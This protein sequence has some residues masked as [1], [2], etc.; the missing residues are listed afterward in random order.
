MQL[1]E[2][3]GGVGSPRCALRNIGVP[4][5]SIDYVEIDEKAVRS[6][7]AMFA[8]ELAY[9]AQD[10]CGW[11]LRPDILVHGSPCQDFSIAGK[12]QGA[13]PNS[14]TRSSL[15]WETI[16]TIKNMGAW[17]PKIVVWEN[18]KNVRSKYM[19]HNH[20]R[21]IDELAKMGYTS[22]FSL[23]DA[24]DFGLPQARQRYFTVSCLGGKAFNFKK[25]KKRP[26]RNVWDFIQPD[27]EVD[28]R[29][30]IKSPSM[31]SRIDPN[32]YDIARLNKLP[33]IRN[34]VCTI[35]TTQDR[36]PNAGIIRRDNGKWRLLTERECW[37]LQGYSD[38]DFENA[39]KGCP[40]KP[41]FK[42]GALYKQAGN[43]IPVTI[44]E[45]MFEA[46]LDGSGFYKEV[47]LFSDVC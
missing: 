16:N 20:N 2:L 26:M 36:C 17:R 30:T 38:A 25:M 23:L 19:V 15:M 40:G 47:N 12:Q 22:T 11:N 3:F 46:M 8:E 5:K 42:N 33:V 34:Y 24:R 14:G 32:N 39:L 13:D 4:V 27:R 7:N 9:K 6:Y 44:F 37:R 29:Y 18:V 43:S 45:S 41:G 31:I 21:Y 10:V 1:L 28:D 35:T